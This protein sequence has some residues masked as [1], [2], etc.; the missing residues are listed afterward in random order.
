M[1]SSTTTVDASARLVDTKTGAVLWENR[2]ILQQGSGD[3]GGGLLGQLVG[4]LV[5]QVINSKT[6]PAHGLSRFV[7]SVMITTKG[8]GLPYGPYRPEAGKI[9]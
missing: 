8:R 6:D 4:A 5:T 3:G 7:N 1:L 2:Q 9:P